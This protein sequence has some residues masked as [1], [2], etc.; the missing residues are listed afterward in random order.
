MLILNLALKNL[1]FSV[2]QIGCFGKHVI[3]NN[4]ALN[5]N[6]QPE[7]FNLSLLNLATAYCYCNTTL[8][9]ISIKDVGTTL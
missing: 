5:L 3:Q 2:L 8:K 4:D 9:D 6:N 1:Q 7:K